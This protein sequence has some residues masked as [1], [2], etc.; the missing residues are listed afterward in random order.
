MLDASLSNP[1]FI[2][3]L[4]LIFAVLLGDATE[5][6]GVPWITGCVLA[7]VLLGPDL[8]GVLTPAAQKVL[9]G[10]L[11]ASL[12]LIA[13][14]IGLQLT[15]GK[16][17]G[18]GASIIWL[19]LVQLLAPLATVLIVLTLL[20]LSW[21]TALIAAAVA[22]ATAPTTTYSVIRRRDASGPFV[23]RALGVLAVNDAATILIF[24]VISAT[25]VAWLGAQTSQG[26]TL[27]ALL[28][29]GIGEALSLVVGVALGGLY[30]VARV[31][32]ADGRPGWQD[33]LRAML[34]A[35][36]L[37]A[38]GAALAFDL[39]HLLT[40]LAMGAVIANGPKGV[41]QGAKPAAIGDVEQPLYMIFFVLAG[42]H[43]P[44]ADVIGHSAILIAA[45]AYVLARVGGKYVAVF[46]GAMALR[47]DLKT[48]RYLGLCFPSQGG[49]AMGLV[50]ACNGSPAVRA[51]PL[52]AAGLVESAVSIVLLGVLVSQ[53]FGPIVIDYAVRRGVADPA[54]A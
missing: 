20:G 14:N 53:I 50:L 54:S 23:D 34:Y 1:L 3:G 43:L 40:P 35:L 46:F 18:L 13:F 52:A 51:L 39:S 27:S 38:V 29:A 17:R 10:F 33:R 41:E 28:K 8:I 24:S 5:R 16:I 21:P 49:A 42:A 4:V 9:G 37:L 15:I 47:L 19:A 6:L 48:R 7:G 31:L 30:L 36:L 11:L 25:A 45:I 2:L 26:A 44:V 22:P 32:V 12:A